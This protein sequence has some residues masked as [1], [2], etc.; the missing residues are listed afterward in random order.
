MKTV[1]LATYPN[2][3]EAHLAVQRLENEG[4]PAFVKALGGGYG[5]DVSQFIS[6]RV[7][8]QDSTC[9]GPRRSWRVERSSETLRLRR[10]SGQIAA[11]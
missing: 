5:I 6:H 4:I 8:V 10:V 1:P 2:E 3:F 11:A 9:R 7:Y